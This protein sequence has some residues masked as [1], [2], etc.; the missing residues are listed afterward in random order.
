MFSFQGAIVVDIAGFIPGR[1]YHETGY[2]KPD[3]G[4]WI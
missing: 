3:T 1:Q 2:R 4:A